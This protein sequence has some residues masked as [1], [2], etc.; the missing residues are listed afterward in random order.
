MSESISDLPP[1]KQLTGLMLIGEI[2]PQEQEFFACHY[3]Q[4]IATIDTGAIKEGSVSRPKFPPPPPV[5]FKLAEKVWQG[6]YID[7]QKLLLLEWVLCPPS[8]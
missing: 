5:P 4:V 6:E 8:C 3:A 7:L 1:R 2:Q